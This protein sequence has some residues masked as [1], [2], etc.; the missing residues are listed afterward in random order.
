MGWFSTRPRVRNCELLVPRSPVSSGNAHGTRS[1]LVLAVG[2]LITLAL[3]VIPHQSAVAQQSKSSKSKSASTGNPFPNR[4]PSP[5]LEGGKEWLNTSGEITL[6]D[7]RGKIV[8]LDFWTYCCIN[9]MHI[10]PDLEYLEKKYSKE[11]VVIG[12]HSG[13]FNAEKDSDNIRQAILRYEIKHPV[14]NDASMTLWRKFEVNTWP[15]FALIDPE[16][17]YCGALSGEGNRENLDIVIGR[18]VAFH[19]SKGTL[20]ETP[21]QFDLE[22]RKALTTPLRFPGKILADGP[23][24][25]LFIADSN[26]NRIVVTDLAGKVQSVIG[27]GAIGSKDGGYDVAQFDHP[28]GLEL[29]GNQLY[30]A[31]TENHQI[32][33]VDLEKKLV[34]TIAGTGKQARQFHQGGPALQSALASP[35]DVRK[36]ADKLYVAMAG[37]HQIWVLNGTDSIRAFAGS[38]KEDILNGALNRAALAQPS[39]IATDGDSLFVVDSEGSAVRKIPTKGQGTVSTIVGSYDLPQGRCLFEFG[40]IDGVG[41]KARLQH[42]LGVVYRDGLLYVAD[43]YNHKIK[44]VDIAKRSSKTFLPATAPGTSKGEKELF[45]PAGL[46]IAG[47]K[48]FIA[49]TNNHRIRVYDFSTKQLTT[50]DL[51]GLEPPKPV[52]SDGDIP[53]AG[54]AKKTSAKTVAAGSHLQFDVALDIP[55]GFKL[56]PLAPVVFRLQAEGKQT[57]V[58]VEHLGVREEVTPEDDQ[59]TIQIPLA[60]KTGTGQFQLTVSYSYCKEG[61]TGGVCKLKSASWVV[62]VTVAKTG[63]KAIELEVE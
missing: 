45:E 4:F 53:V 38:G 40:D 25:R 13:K 54:K 46:S 21:L 8:L 27:T 12:V 39:G 59:V 43:S 50:L 20:D 41:D 57:L 52:V 3:L 31:D 22:A 51:S 16:G 62:P 11:L 60:G 61:Q 28:Q 24:N 56:N 58:P 29:D 35:W 48:M 18:V 30:V 14:L 5:S 17:N 9:C 63:G 10:L 37:F 23:G 36:V 55:E 26:H 2:V 32:R 47:E 44:V 33:V 15:T 6:Q 34:K 49:D 19:K 1:H 42:P 7:L